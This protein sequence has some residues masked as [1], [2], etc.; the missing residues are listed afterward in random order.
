MPGF[1]KTKALDEFNKRAFKHICSCTSDLKEKREW[2]RLGAL[3]TL[4]NICL[5]TDIYF[6]RELLASELETN[7]FSS[8]FLNAESLTLTLLQLKYVTNSAKASA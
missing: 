7:I 2:F 8:I 6:K 3:N 1:D 4:S 5:S